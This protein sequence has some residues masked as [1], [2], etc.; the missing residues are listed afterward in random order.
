MSKKKFFTVLA[1][2]CAVLILGGFLIYD[3]LEGEY[4]SN[5]YA[6]AA[7]VSQTLTGFRGK[8]TSEEVLAR[9]KEIENSKISWRI[10]SS[11]TAKVNKKKSCE[12][13]SDTAEYIEKM[14]KFCEDCDGAL[15]ITAG[16]LT[17][18]WNIGEEDFRVPDENEIKNLLKSV[19]YKKVKLENNTVTIDDNQ[20][21]DFGAVGK[22]IA[23]DEALE[24]IKENEI[25]RAVVSVGGSVLLYSEDEKEEFTVGIRDPKGEAGEYMALL[26]MNS[27]FVSTSG[28]YERYSE[29][30]DGK[31]YHHILSTETGYPVE[32]DVASVTVCCSSGMMSDALSTACFILGFEKSEKLLEKY[33]AQAVFVYESGEVRTTDEIKDKLEIKIDGYFTEK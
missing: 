9:I 23:C 6:M 28:S 4:S 14:L 17:Q 32:N 24:V 22:G 1:A 13:S 16:A 5:S 8:K 31:R 26:K 25:K 3:S 21:L 19:D 11:D 27:G 7:S 33:G 12:V 30:A 2:V 20:L 15:D 18:N 29:T 10:S